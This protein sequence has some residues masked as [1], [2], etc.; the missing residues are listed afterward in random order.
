MR[1]KVKDVDVFISHS[2][3]AGRW[4]KYLA[5]CY[6]LNLGLAAKAMT[7]F[8]VLSEA[9]MLAFA[10]MS[11]HV[12]FVFLLDF[13]ILIFFL[14]FFF[15][16]HLTCGVWGP[17]FWL[18]RLCVDQTDAK[19]K[20]EGIAGLPTIVAN[21]SELL[22]LWDKS[23]YQRLW[24]NFELSIFFKGN[25][26]KNLRLVPLWLTPW[27]LTT[28]L[29]SY[30]SARLVA[31]FTESDPSFGI[32]DTSKL[33]GAAGN[34]LAFGLKRF[35]GYAVATEGYLF[36]WLLP[37]MVGIV[38]F[39][40]KL[41]GHRDMLE[42]MKSFDVRNAKCAVESDRLAI[43]AQVAELF[44]GL[45]D[46]IIAVS[47]EVENS[48]DEQQEP[49]RQHAEPTN[50]PPKLQERAAFTLLLE[51]IDLSLTYSARLAV[52]SVTGFAN[53]DDCLEE[54]NKYVQGPMHDAVVEDLGDAA[55]PCLLRCVRFLDK[56]FDS[57][58]LQAPA[59]LGS[60]LLIFNLVQLENAFASASL[61]TFAFTRHP[62]FLCFFL[63]AVVAAM[64]QHFLLF[65]A[66]SRQNSNR[67]MRM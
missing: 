40:K 45:E 41:D 50:S 51:L 14:V 43:E 11:I 63:L 13:P 22:V 24:C 61:E 27:L 9:S 6:F 10:D 46:P 3:S 17:N 47:V 31:V 66:G 35:W 55:Y 37:I 28:M 25:G 2:W 20:A 18:D 8:V 60:G 49:I 33:S 7:A 54:F 29:L 38:S 64:F 56:S 19:T 26:L 30:F 23:Y 21:S 53:H 42:S 39:Q 52:R 34:A 15:G 58:F 32:N 57:G 16:Q 65:G 67:E 44:D 48:E 62:A 36:F 4:D 12:M 59:A 1:S 5:V